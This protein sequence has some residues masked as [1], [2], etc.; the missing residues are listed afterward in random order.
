MCSSLIM[1]ISDGSKP[2]RKEMQQET[3]ASSVKTVLLRRFEQV[4]PHFARLMHGRQRFEV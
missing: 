3:A 4:V 2:P 1:A